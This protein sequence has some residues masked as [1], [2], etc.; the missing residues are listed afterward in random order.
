MKNFNEWIVYIYRMNGYPESKIL[1]YEQ[2]CRREAIIQNNQRWVEQ[3][4]GNA[5]QG[6]AENTPVPKGN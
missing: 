1:E 4:R 5:S 2:N 6:K 3:S